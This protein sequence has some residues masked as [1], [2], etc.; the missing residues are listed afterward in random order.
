MFVVVR[1]RSSSF[2][3]KTPPAHMFWFVYRLFLPLT[4]RQDSHCAVPDLG[5]E[6][7][8]LPC[9]TVTARKKWLYRGKA[10]ADF[11]RDESVQGKNRFEGSF[12]RIVH[13]NRRGHER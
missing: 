7:S 11:E 4:H 2:F 3:L 1:R 9:L 6:T 8:F 12:S 13:E 10:L 5:A